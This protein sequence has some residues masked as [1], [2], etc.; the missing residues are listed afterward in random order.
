MTP[1]DAAEVLDHA[2]ELVEADRFARERVVWEPLPAE[3]EP[4]DDPA[5]EI[6]ARRSWAPTAEL[7]F[8]DDRGA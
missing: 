1:D 5:A 4:V 6:I 3:P 8:D 2:A 7:P